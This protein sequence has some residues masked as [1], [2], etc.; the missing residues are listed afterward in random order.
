MVD[1]LHDYEH[2]RAVN[3]ES[4][5]ELMRFCSVGQPKRFVFVSS[6]SVFSDVALDAAHPL[7]ESAE[8]RTVGAPTGGYNQSKWAAE[9]LLADAQRHGLSVSVVRFGEIMPHSRLGVP[10][11]GAMAHLLIKNSLVLGC[12]P[13][14]RLEFDYVPVDSAAA[15]ITAVTYAGGHT[16]AFNVFHP[17]GARLDTIV[18]EIAKRCRVVAREVPYAQF[19][20]K[21]V[22]H[23]A[24]EDASAE[25]IALS[26]ML[27]TPE[28]VGNDDPMAKLF[29]TRRN[30][31]S[32]VQAMNVSHETGLHIPKIDSQVLGGY[33][34][35][36]Q[37]ELEPIG[38]TVEHPYRFG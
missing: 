8:L 17:T 26:L 22:E 2:H 7:S 33:A 35:F 28:H 9:V 37:R 25:L 4:T 36:V 16:G 11:R 24:R 23:G 31:L 38:G 30:A 18:T 21:V 27:P 15:F 3:V 10:N 6:L 32:A 20:A 1:F 5:V 29:F 14:S 34:E 19:H 13:S 12:Y